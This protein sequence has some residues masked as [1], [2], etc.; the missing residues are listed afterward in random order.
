MNKITGKNLEALEA[1]RGK[2]PD[3]PLRR[4]KRKSNGQGQQEPPQ[5]RLSD[6]EAQAYGEAFDALLTLWQ[7]LGALPQGMLPTH[8][9]RAQAAATI[10]LQP[11][12]TDAMRVAS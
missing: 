11:L 10:R 6:A 9:R 4:S 1:L 7:A 12:L 3:R 5:E 8:V 2:L